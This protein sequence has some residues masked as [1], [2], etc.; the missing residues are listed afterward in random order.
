[1]DSRRRAQTAR[2]ENTWLTVGS[3]GMTTRGDW[4]DDTLSRLLAVCD[5]LGFVVQDDQ[6][7]RDDVFDLVRSLSHR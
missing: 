5:G 7:L 3:L 4:V 1:M 6:Q 2:W